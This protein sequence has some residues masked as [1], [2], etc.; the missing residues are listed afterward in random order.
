MNTFYLKWITFFSI[1]WS[2]W[3]IMES[4]LASQHYN[5]IRQLGNDAVKKYIYFFKDLM[6]AC[7]Y[8]LILDTDPWFLF[9]FYFLKDC[10][11]I[12]LV[13]V[14]RAGW[15]F[16]ATLGPP[17]TKIHG[18]IF[19]TPNCYRILCCYSQVGRVRTHIWETR[20]LE[21][22][23]CC[24]ALTHSAKTRFVWQICMSAVQYRILL[25]APHR[26]PV[27]QASK[28]ISLGISCHPENE[29]NES[30]F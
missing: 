27:P 17:R 23:Y 2:L 16:Y 10:F 9:L 7:R 5:F 19:L 1:K 22:E 21:D 12:T 3:N 6:G 13:L 15:L 8:S 30:W 24:R 25:L 28:L 4:L 18:R 14:R 26:G 20:C 29:L 11:L